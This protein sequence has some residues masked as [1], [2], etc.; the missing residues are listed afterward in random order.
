MGGGGVL[1]APASKKQKLGASNFN[2]K[3]YQKQYY[4]NTKQLNL[5]EEATEEMRV[6]TIWI[7]GSKQTIRLHRKDWKQVEEEK[8]I[9]QD[10]Q[11]VLVK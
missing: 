7:Q 1:S 9:D 6:I 4:F 10:H 2:K 11:W 8:L 5:V 3:S